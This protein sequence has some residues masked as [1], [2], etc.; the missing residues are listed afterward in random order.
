M[1]Y[2]GVTL[3]LTII[4]MAFRYYE[5]FSVFS[6]FHLS[7]ILGFQMIM[8]ELLEAWLWYLTCLWKSLRPCLG[9]LMVE[10]GPFV[11]V[12]EY[13]VC[14]IWWFLDDY[15]STVRGMASTF[16]KLMKACNA[17]LGISDGWPWPIC[18]RHRNDFVFRTLIL[19]SL[20]TWWAVA[21][22]HIMTY[23]W[24]RMCTLVEPLVSLWW[25]VQPK[26]RTHLVCMYHCIFP[27]YKSPLT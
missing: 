4:I 20:F 21:L 8:G 10:L 16:Y 13:F 18:E 9:L 7:I 23:I 3:K 12:T 6:W 19:H 2:T 5:E 25:C 24:V 11:K 15:G 14:E 22:S 26:A 27:I 17:L 1:F